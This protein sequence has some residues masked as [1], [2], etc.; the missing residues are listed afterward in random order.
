MNICI[1]IYSLETTLY[2]RYHVY[3]FN[4]EID[5]TIII[6]QIR[7]PKLKCQPLHSLSSVKCSSEKLIHWLW[8]EKLNNPI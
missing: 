2:I 1:V 5:F 3:E 8:L 6:L 7:I 4:S